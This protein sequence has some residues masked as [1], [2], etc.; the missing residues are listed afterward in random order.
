MMISSENLLLVLV[1]LPFVGSAI[2]ATLPANARNAEAWLAGSIAAIMFIIAAGLYSV[3]GDGSVLRRE[4]QRGE[5]LRVDTGCLVAFEES[6]DYTI[7]FVP[8]IKNKIFGGEG[9]FYVKMTGPGPVWLQTLPFSR[10]ADRIFAAAPS[11]GGSRQG[12]GSVLGGLGD[13]IGGR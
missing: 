10:L 6:V 12:E 4:L 9:L 3:I 8:G 11:Q 7:E 1:L 2:A 5:V 13:L